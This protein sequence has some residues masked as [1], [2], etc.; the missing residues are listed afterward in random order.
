MRI[1]NWE[2]GIGNWELGI[3]NW[4]WKIVNISLVVLVS[5]S[6]YLPIFL[7][8]VYTG[9]EPGTTQCYNINYKFTHSKF[10]ILNN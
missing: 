4:E 3:G 1:G 9:L 8:P 10:Y 7:L 2:L 6:S 5:L